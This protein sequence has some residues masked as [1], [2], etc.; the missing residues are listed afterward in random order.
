MGYIPVS[1]LNSPNNSGSFSST[2]TSSSEGISFIVSAAIASIS[3]GDISFWCPLLF[4]LVG[5]APP[6]RAANSASRSLS[7]SSSS[8]WTLPSP[9]SKSLGISNKPY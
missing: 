4:G 3:P 5:P 1:S 7:P 9:V 2:D 8:S 6:A